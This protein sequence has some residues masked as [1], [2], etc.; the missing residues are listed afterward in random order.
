MPGQWGACPGG[1]VSGWRAPVEGVASL[2]PPDRP[3]C[4]SASLLSLPGEHLG[5]QASPSS[6]AQTAS[7]DQQTVHD[8]PGHLR[9]PPWSK[10]RRPAADRPDCRLGK[11]Q[12]SVPQGRGCP[13]LA[14]VLG[15]ALEKLESQA[16]SLLH[17]QATVPEVRA[18]L[19]SHPGNPQ[20]LRESGCFTDKRAILSPAKEVRF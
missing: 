2:R 7:R 8:N 13:R 4:L 17:F 12:R 19:R 18:S 15:G 6:C 3:R 11:S 20:A 9:G 1:Q 10:R 14:S 16:H 5:P